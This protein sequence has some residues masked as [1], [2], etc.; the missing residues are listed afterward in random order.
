MQSVVCVPRGTISN[1]WCVY[2]VVQKAICGVCTKWYKKQSMVCVP[3]GTIS[4]L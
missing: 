1:L 2:Q 3:R 4:N